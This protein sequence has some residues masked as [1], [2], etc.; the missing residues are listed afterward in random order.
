MPKL[1]MPGEALVLALPTFCA[2][3]R[4]ASETI[5]GIMAA[6]CRKYSVSQMPVSGQ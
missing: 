5:V 2:N 3:Y 4:A 6:I 1:E